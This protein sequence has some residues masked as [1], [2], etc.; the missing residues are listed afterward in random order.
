MLPSSAGILQ[1]EPMEWMKNKPVTLAALCGGALSLAVGAYLGSPLF[2]GL[3]AVFFLASLIVWKWGYWLGPLLSGA[4]GRS[5]FSPPFEMP[6]KQ[7]VLIK[8]TDEG[9][10][11][12]V[13]M[14][15]ELRDTASFKSGEQKSMLMEM[16]ERAVSSLR[17]PVKLSMLVCALDQGDYIQKLEEKRSLAEHKKA[18]LKGKHDSDDAAYLERQIEALTAQIGRLSGGEKPMQ[19]LAY[20]STTA[21]GL[22]REEA[23]AKVRA[24]AQESAAVLSNALSCH[25][26]PLVGEELLA[27]FEWERWGPSSRAD[28]ADRTF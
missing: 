22:T 17:Y 15:V 28:M 6:P 24:Q 10:F 11:A 18:Q 4:G 23:L 16:F 1:C 12:S 3:A 21:S 19:V 25:V 27:S 9:Y 26:Y 8:K 5:L 7:D 20:A 2:A 13:F 14:A